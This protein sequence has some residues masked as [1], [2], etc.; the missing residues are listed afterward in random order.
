MGHYDECREGYCGCGQSLDR[1]GNCNMGS[2]CPLRITL[3][4]KIET[5]KGT[6]YSEVTKFIFRDAIEIIN[7]LVKENNNLRKKK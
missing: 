4:D 3:V 6:Q 5:F 2:K 7:E 1:K